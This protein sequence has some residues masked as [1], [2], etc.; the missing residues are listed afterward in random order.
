M[1]SQ[2]NESLQYG[3]VAIRSIEHQSITLIANEKW[4]RRDSLRL[5]KLRARRSAG[6]TIGR[7]VAGHFC[8]GVSH[9]VRIQI[10]RGVLALALLVGAP[11][12]LETKRPR[13][14]GTGVF[15]GLIA[16]SNL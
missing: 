12:C 7:V 15:S 5:S 14:Y 6:S 13:R 1:V 16:V 3:H 11:I 10:F 4:V 8:G 2:C 9:G